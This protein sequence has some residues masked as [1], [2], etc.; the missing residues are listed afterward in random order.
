[1]SLAQMTFFKDTTDGWNCML[2][3][4]ASQAIVR[5]VDHGRGLRL[6]EQSTGAILRVRRRFCAPS[7]HC[8]GMVQGYITASIS[9][10]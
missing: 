2:M 1:M 9:A 4:R 6:T 3:V 8:K 5:W 10:L 7:Q